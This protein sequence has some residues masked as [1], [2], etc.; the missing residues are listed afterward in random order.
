MGFSFLHFE[1]RGE[2][3]SLIDLKSMSLPE[4]NAVIKELG[5]P[6]YRGKQVY[7]WL[8]KGVNSFEEM[9]NINKELCEKLQQK[10]TISYVK[11]E[12]KLQS[13]LDE[14]V[15]YLFKLSDGEFI[16]TVVMK[17]KHG[18]SIC[19]STQVGCRMGCGFCAST[20]GGLSRNL[21]AGEMLSQITEAQR[22]LDIRISNIVLMGMGEPLDNYDNVLKFLA[23]VSDDLGLNIGMRHI[24]LSTCGIVDKIYE[25]LEK[26]LQ[27]TLSVSL[28]APNDEIRDQIMPINKKWRVDEL[29]TAC[30]KY[31]KTT[32]RRISFEYTMIEGLNDSD[33]CAILLSKKLKGL[34]CH[35]NLIPT[36]QVHLNKFNKSGTAKILHFSKILTNYGINVTIRRTLG[37]DINASCGQLKGEN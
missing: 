26:K 2:P 1:K 28:H 17:Y 16:E 19:I 27:L 3:L 4:I 10:Y 25:L 20:I 13:S 35:V 11:I 32:N 7:S 37:S 8:S 24:S 12:K 9:K 6:E 22:D 21:T 29:L 36:N 33:E 34:L 30:K 18:Y 14:T 5:Q 31:I 15:K 23:L